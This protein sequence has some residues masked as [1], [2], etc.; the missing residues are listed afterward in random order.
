[1]IK[2]LIIE[3][4]D[5]LNSGLCYTLQQSEIDPF[6]ALSFRE[7]EELLQKE[8][9]DI[10]LLDIDLP[11]GDWFQFVKNVTSASS[12]PF[13]L[14]TF[15]EMSRKT[16]ESLQM[17]ADD[18]VTQPF[19]VKTLLEKLR[20]V[21]RRRSGIKE[22]ELYRCGNLKIDFENRMLEK[23]DTSVSLTP[24]EFE[25]LRYFFENQNQVL[26]RE[27]LL[28]KL[29]IYRGSPVNDHML[30]LYISKLRRK[31]SDKTHEYI[32]T[33]YGFGYKWIKTC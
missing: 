4:D 7:A 11:D 22:P 13:V 15:H 3:H 28:E 30:S 8:T 1:M 29:S 25:L 6:S 33:V 17:K 26:S 24:I 23:Y 27:F 21:L 31:L 9:F 5:I 32:E 12:T 20:T 16:M 2:L 19:N 18:Y 14:L 10:I